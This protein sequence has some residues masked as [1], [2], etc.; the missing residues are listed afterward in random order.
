MKEARLSLNSSIVLLVK[1]IYFQKVMKSRG[2]FYE[3]KLVMY[4]VSTL[5]FLLDTNLPPS[6]PRLSNNLPYAPRSYAPFSD[7]RKNNVKKVCDNNLPLA[8]YGA[9]CV[10]NSLPV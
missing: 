8:G 7:F 1:I 5:C 9:I 2:G 6:S 4:E 10:E 3:L